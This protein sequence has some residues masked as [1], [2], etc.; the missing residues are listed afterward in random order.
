MGEGAGLRV[1]PAPRALPVVP[2]P[3]SFWAGPERFPLRGPGSGAALTPCP[4][5]VRVWGGRPRAGPFG[6][7]V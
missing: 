7:G 4:G 6:L 5:R 1:G 2:P 3:L